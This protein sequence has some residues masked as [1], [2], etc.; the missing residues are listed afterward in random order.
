MSSTIVVL[1]T[2][3]STWAGHIMPSV[4]RPCSCSSLT[5]LYISA[6]EEGFRCSSFSLLLHESAR[7]AGNRCCLESKITAGCVRPHSLIS[8]PCGVVGRAPRMDLACRWRKSGRSSRLPTS[9]GSHRR[10]L[11]HSAMAWMHATWTT[12]TLS[13]KKPCFVI[14][15]RSL[16]S[17]SLASF[18]H[19]LCYSLNEGCA[20]IQTPC[21]HV[22]CILNR[23]TPLLTCIIAVSFRRM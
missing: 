23:M 3:W 1:I 8:A 20:S 11:L 18:I 7:L 10:S 2:R 21:Q 17:A 9:V 12:L 14:R 6:P 15:V 13:G 19:W 22:S 16:A 4:V 5:A